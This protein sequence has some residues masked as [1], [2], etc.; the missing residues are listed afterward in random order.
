MTAAL[1]IFSPDGEPVPAPRL[2]RRHSC[3][4]ACVLWDGAFYSF[5][6]T[7]GAIVR[8]LWREARRGTPELR[9]ET[10]LEAAG[11][12]GGSIAKVFDAHPAWGVLI[13]PGTA[14]GTYKLNLAKGGAR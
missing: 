10:L 2:A 13:I 5:T 4:Y 3:D 7:Q 8:L 11:S 14:R 9:G 12:E 1:R 6:P